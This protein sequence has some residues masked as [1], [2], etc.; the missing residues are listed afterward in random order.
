VTFQHQ[1]NLVRNVMQRLE[2]A[3]G[4]VHSLPDL[5]DTQRML[6]EAC[7]D[8]LRVLGESLLD[9]L[10]YLVYDI[11]PL[12]RVSTVVLLSV[13]LW[14][15]PC[16]SF[17]ETRVCVCVR[18]C[19]R[20]AVFP[21]RKQ[22]LMQTR[23]S[24]KSAIENLTKTMTEAQEKNHTDPIDLSSRTLH[25]QLMWRPVMYTHRAGADGTNAPLPSG[26]KF[27]LF[28]SPPSYVRVPFTKP[29]CFLTHVRI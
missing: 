23:C 27:S 28:L 12:P 20:A 25:G 22:N 19:V 18:A 8:K 1:L 26:K 5:K 17:F 11:G 4:K 2:C 6:S 7:T 3:Q 14:I 10:L 9:L 16:V 29:F 15:F 24:F 13:S 21:K